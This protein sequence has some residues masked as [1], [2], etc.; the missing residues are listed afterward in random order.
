MLHFNYDKIEGYWDEVFEMTPRFTVDTKIPYAPINHG[1]R[2]LGEEADH[3]LDF[4]CG[5]GKA[6][7][8]SARY[9][10]KSGV[11]LDISRK[12]VETA[13]GVVNGS[14]LEGHFNFEKG[15][16]ESLSSMEEGIFDGAIL[17]NLLD[18]LYPEDGK[19]LVK[20]L[21]HVLKKGAAVLIKLNPIYETDA[22]SL[23]PDFKKIGDNVYEEESGLLF[24]NMDET[25]I[26]DLLGDTFEYV[27]G[28]DVEMKDFE[29][30]NRMYLL[31]KI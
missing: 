18:N 20:A 21:G 17:F 9:G 14:K 7:I 27:D 31:R 10:V 24:W 19:A 23:D 28:Y 15:S 2:W 4:G 30:V 16:I 26:N 6:L 11:G 25:I 3:V 8:V 22:L 1:L 13:N 29:T 5:N 12:A